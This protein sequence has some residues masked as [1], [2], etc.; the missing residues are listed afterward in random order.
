MNPKFPC[1]PVGNRRLSKSIK[2][3]VVNSNEINGSYGLPVDIVLKELMELKTVRDPDVEK[4]IK[5]LWD[6]LHQKQYESKEFSKKYRQLDRLLGS[7]D[8][9]LMLMR[10]EIAKLEAQKGNRNAGNKKTKNT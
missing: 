8:E 4:E 7:E 6:L 10:I 9:D 3:S 5:S 2:I 1:T